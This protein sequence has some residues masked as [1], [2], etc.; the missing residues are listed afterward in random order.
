MDSVGGPSPEAPAV[1]PPGPAMTPTPEPLAPPPSALRRG[2]L[3]LWDWLRGY[4]LSVRMAREAAAI[5]V[6]LTLYRLGRGLV[7]GKTD[8][9]TDNAYWLI[10]VEEAMGLFVERAWQ[11]WT[12]QRPELMDF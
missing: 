12:L 10:R 5:T 4:S 6:M 2:G 7:A 1:A 11:Q 3:A 8:Q 9:A